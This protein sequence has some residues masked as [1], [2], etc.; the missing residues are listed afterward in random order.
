VRAG[1]SAGAEGDGSCLP[2]GPSTKTETAGG[3]EDTADAAGAVGGREAAA[4]PGSM[5]FEG[6]AGRMIAENNLR[7]Q[8]HVGTG[9]HTPHRNATHRPSSPAQG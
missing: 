2:G 5:A 6:R 9:C 3:E 1:A 7:A 4:V 8:V